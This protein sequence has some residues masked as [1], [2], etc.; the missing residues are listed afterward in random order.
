MCHIFTRA[1]S[2]ISSFWTNEHIEVPRKT[3][4]G[5]GEASLIFET[6][7]YI[8]YVNVKFG[9]TSSKNDSKIHPSVPLILRQEFIKTILIQGS[10]LHFLRSQKDFY[11]PMWTL[12]KPRPG[13]VVSLFKISWRHLSKYCHQITLGMSFLEENKVQ[14]H[15]AV[16]QLLD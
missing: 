10:L 5:V 2:I 1:K 6:L 14:Y 11:E 7:Q 12:D 13:D 9:G 3:I 15:Q 4:A 16:R 8:Y